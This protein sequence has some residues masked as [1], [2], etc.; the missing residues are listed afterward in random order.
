MSNE[1]GAKAPQTEAQ[2]KAAQRARSKAAGLVKVRFPE[3][4][5]SPER[6]AHIEASLAELLHSI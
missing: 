5:V 4:W 1:N 2:R 6:A 3:L